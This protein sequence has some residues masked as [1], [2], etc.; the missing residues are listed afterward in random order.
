M[1]SRFIASLL[2]TISKASRLVEG[3]PGDPGGGKATQEDADREIDM[4]SLYI[5]K[6]CCQVS[7]KRKKAGDPQVAAGL[8]LKVVL[9]G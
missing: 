7:P 5:G 8:Q 1:R 9:T 6:T 3:V 2:P 4:V